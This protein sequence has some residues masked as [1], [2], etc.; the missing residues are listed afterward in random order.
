MI[1][2]SFLTENFI[3]ETLSMNEEELRIFLENLCKRKDYIYFIF[4]PGFNYVSIKKNPPKN[5]KPNNFSNWSKYIQYLH[6]LGRIKDYTFFKN[7]INNLNEDYLN[8]EFIKKSL[9][10]KL[11][12]LSFKGLKIKNPSIKVKSLGDS[13]FEIFNNVDMLIQKNTLLTDSI[14]NLKDRENLFFDKLGGLCCFNNTFICIDRFILNPAKDNKNIYLKT[15]IKLLNG[16]SIKNII[17]L[18]SDPYIEKYKKYKNEEL[19]KNKFDCINDHLKILFKEMY[20]NKINIQLFLMIPEELKKFHCRYFSWAQLPED[21]SFDLKDLDNL[22]DQIIVSIQ[23]DKGAGIFEEDT[24][25]GNE[26]KFNYTTK[27]ELNK[28]INQ[29]LNSDPT[30][31]ESSFKYNSFKLWIEENYPRDKVWINHNKVLNILKKSKP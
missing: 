15:P 7:Y 6:R 20:P 8:G 19:N 9:N 23:P 11:F 17:I 10:K 4:E 27:S 18:T 21:N 14:K 22:E 12:Y 28:K 26:A 25:Y 31:Y 24:E 16:S 2:V 1:I 30:Q 5:F 13:L 29:M 3:R